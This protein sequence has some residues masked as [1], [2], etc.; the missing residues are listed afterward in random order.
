MY[1]IGIQSAV[2]INDSMEFQ[3]LPLSQGYPSVRDFA[4]PSGE[5]PSLTEGRI[6]SLEILY[7]DQQKISS[8]SLTEGQND[9]FHLFFYLGGAIPDGGAKCCSLQLAYI[10]SV[11]W[12]L[13]IPNGHVAPALGI[14][15]M[16]HIYL[17]SKL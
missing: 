8:E 4:P 15:M 10:Q 9:H 1:Y 17:M 12:L 5:E 3:L 2:I 7:P 14:V 6:F 16:F 11:Q 13:T